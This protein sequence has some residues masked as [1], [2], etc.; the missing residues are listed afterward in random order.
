MARTSG[1]RSS[2]RTLERLAQSYMILDGPG[3]EP[4][5]WDGFRVRNLGLAVARAAAERFGGDPERFRR[6]ASGVVRRY[7][8]VDSSSGLAQ[9]M[10]LIPDLGRWSREAR[11][12]AAAILK[13]KHERSEVRYLRLMQAHPRLRAA[14]RW[15]AGACF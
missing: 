8:G 11:S 7:L 4:G 2:K 10:S 12:A 14:F 3:A 1:H 15:L 5:A 6:T 13:A 9:A